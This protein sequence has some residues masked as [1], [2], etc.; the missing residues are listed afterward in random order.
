M[1]ADY[2]DGIQ[3]AAL[4]STVL[5]QRLAKAHEDEAKYAQKEQSALDKLEQIDSARANVAASHV[6]ASELVSQRRV[7]D[8]NKPSYKIE[9]PRTEEAF[10]TKITLGKAIGSLS[11]KHSAFSNQSET[12]RSTATA[13][14]PVS[15]RSYLARRAEV[16]AGKRL[17]KQ[18]L[19]QGRAKSN[20][21]VFGGG[22]GLGKQANTRTSIRR[23]TETRSLRKEYSS[24]A[25]TPGD[26]ADSKN[27]Y[28]VLKR[29]LLA[30]Y[31]AGELTD[32]EFVSANHAARTRVSQTAAMAKNGPMSTKQFLQRK[33]KIKGTVAAA[34][35][36]A[37][38]RTVGRERMGAIYTL[39]RAQKPSKQLKT[40][41][42][43]K[44]YSR[45]LKT[46]VRR[47]S[48]AH[49]AQAEIEAELA[50]RDNS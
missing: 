3:F 26:A 35:V 37:V 45:R 46:A 21:V 7:T 49:A 40:S 10:V 20:E 39:A 12:R 29:D 11:V 6:E 31:D 5:E 19:R 23:F 13:S 15:E 25:I 34:P 42:K 30:K 28:D 17:K 16:N 43:E 47:G 33:D 22:I 9:L 2:L 14:T 32:G 38:R 1:P 24:P 4:N 36:R 44:L 8:P 48:K 18:S 41:L 27:D 50:R